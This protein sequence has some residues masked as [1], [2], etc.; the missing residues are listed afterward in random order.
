LGKK[1]GNGRLGP[2]TGERGGKAKKLR[3]QDSIISNE[4]KFLIVGGVTGREEVAQVGMS[5]LED[6]ARG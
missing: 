4:E 2:Y 3:E 5:L 6:S 1:E